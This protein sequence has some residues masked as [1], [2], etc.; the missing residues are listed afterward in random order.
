MAGDPE[1]SLDLLERA[2]ENGWGDR[3]WLET[4]SDLESLRDNDRF[5]AILD[6]V[7]DLS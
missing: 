1:K 7:D 5:K 2:V 6:R 4:D 3:A